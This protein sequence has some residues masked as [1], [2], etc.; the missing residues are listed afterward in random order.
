MDDIDKIA[1]GLTMER[2]FQR[3]METSG[4]SVLATGLTSVFAFALGANS[5]LPS[6]QWFCIY[7]VGKPSM[8]M[9]CMSV[10]CL[11]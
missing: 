5:R 1:P 7:A 6:I 8:S 3:L 11:S 9:Y 4:L 2:R 10:L